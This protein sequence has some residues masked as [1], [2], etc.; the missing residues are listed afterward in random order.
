MVVFRQQP[1]STLTLSLSAVSH[2]EK[3]EKTSKSEAAETVKVSRVEMAIKYS[4]GN[5]NN[6]DAMSNDE[7]QV[8][9]KVLEWTLKLWLTPVKFI[10]SGN[11]AEHG[12]NNRSKEHCYTSM[13]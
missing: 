3:G 9:A 8:A 7:E 13:F 10:T 4:Y 6:N 1:Y 2:C 12:K 5:K 11:G